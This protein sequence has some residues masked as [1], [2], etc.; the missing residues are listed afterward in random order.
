MRFNRHLMALALPLLLATAAP[1]RAETAPA[2]EQR[3]LNVQGTGPRGSAGLGDRITVTVQGLTQIANNKCRSLTL[4]LNRSPLTGMP[5]ESCDLVQG[6]VTFILDRNPEIDQNDTAWR[7]LLGSPSG[8]FKPVSVSIGASDDV[9]VPTD[10]REFNIFVIS[11]KSFY[12]FIV[13]ISFAISLFVLLCAR[14]PIIRDSSPI[15]GGS[16]PPFSLTKFLAAFWLFLVLAGY[17]LMWMITGELDSVTD[18]VLV[19][20]AIGSTTALA[21]EIIDTVHVDVSAPGETKGAPHLP[22]PSR[23]FFADLL[24]DGSGIMSIYRFQALAWNI[25]LGAIFCGEIYRNLAM[26]EFDAVLLGLMGISNSTY[27]AFKFPENK[28]KSLAGKAAVR[29]ADGAQPAA[30]PTVSPNP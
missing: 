6:E 24:T 1:A 8:P 19:L 21:S 9:Y 28:K 5:P 4:F 11:R 12:V 22:G 26:P 3:V 14:T 25:V 10:V 13:A 29:A 7:R 18:S 20:L 16:M 23:G 2:S 27:V 30:P 17:F 15:A